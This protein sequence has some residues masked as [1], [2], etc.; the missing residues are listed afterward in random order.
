MTEQNTN[1]PESAQ[2]AED[3]FFGVK[4]II[5]QEDDASEVEVAE[6]EA[7]PAKAPPQ[8][9][10]DELSSYSE[11]VQKRIKKLT[12]E[13][14]EERRQREAIEREREEAVRFAQ[15]ALQ[16]SQQYEQVINHGEG[17]L[18]NQIKDRAV[19]MLEQAK[20]KYRKAYEEGDTEA[21]IAAQDE[22]L[23]WKAE[24]FAAGQQ[25]Q[26][27]QQ[28]L[29]QYQQYQQYQ[30]MMAQQAPP[31]QPTIPRPT[32]QAAE[33]AQENPWF[34][35]PEYKDMQAL[36]FG[37]HEKLMAQGV[38]ADTEEYY[39]EINRQV[40]Q[41]FPEYFAG[42]QGQVAPASTRQ[43]QSSVVAPAQRNNGAKPRQVKLTQTQLAVAK[44]LGLT[45]EQYARESMKE[46]YHG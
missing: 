45:P 39:A 1:A 41:R 23:N 5:G 30:Q 37:V 18:I 43:N 13:K 3:K 8:V 14:N 33:W 44:K 19:A 27:Y 9:D 2:S 42:E 25:E 34:H 40:R 20:S 26:N 12:W 32:Q 35:D 7:S 46:M 22:M 29:Q 4:S 6:S 17:Y 36:A 21:V 10:E 11:N 15:Q 16:R 31:Q 28:R 24:L 38:R